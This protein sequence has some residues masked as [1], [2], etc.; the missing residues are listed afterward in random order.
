VYSARQPVTVEKRVPVATVTNPAS[1]APPVDIQAVVNTAVKTALAEQEKKTGSLLAAA[2]EKHQ[3]EERAMAMR[4]SDYLTNVEKRMS[5]NRA[6]AM[7]Y[8]SNKVGQ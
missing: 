3:M 4:V 7:D 6:V 1:A 2:E 5:Y 8:S